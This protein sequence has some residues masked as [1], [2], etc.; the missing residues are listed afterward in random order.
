MVKPAVDHSLSSFKILKIDQVP[1]L[2][3]NHQ[4]E[5]VKV[6]LGQ[7]EIFHT[8]KTSLVSHITS[9]I[10]Q[11]FQ[12]QFDAPN[13]RL[14]LKITYFECKAINSERDKR[15]CSK[16]VV[17]FYQRRLIGYILIWSWPHR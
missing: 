15:T 16:K 10:T 2:N 4:V 6:G 1:Q 17:F 12:T 7:K 13:I 14:L 8:F 9:Y 11:F 3:F 5:G